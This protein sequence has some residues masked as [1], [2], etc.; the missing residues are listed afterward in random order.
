MRQRLRHRMPTRKLPRQ[1]DHSNAR[2]RRSPAR[3]RTALDIDAIG[4]RLFQFAR[5]LDYEAPRLAKIRASYELE[6]SGMAL[7]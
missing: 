1:V 7:E 5:Q 6:V 3:A 4:N 2:G